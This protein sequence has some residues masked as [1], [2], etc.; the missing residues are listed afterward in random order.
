MS[1]LLEFTQITAARAHLKEIYDSAER[2]VPAVVRREDDAPVA[3]VRRDDL[4]RA[5]RA[6]CPLDP[7]VRFADDGHV[8]LW[9][10]GLPVSA[11]AGD[12]SA[13]ERGLIEALRDYADVWVEDL[14]RYPHHED[15]WG[16]VNL[17]LLSTD[18]ELEAH[19]F[20]ED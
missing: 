18:S 15:A 12:L 8:S 2:H 13:V 16:V 7:Q 11:Q 1:S 5:L 4:H 19:L 9:L 3:V 6:L 20:G 10:D 17:V 14:S